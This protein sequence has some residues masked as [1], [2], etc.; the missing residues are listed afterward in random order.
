VVLDRSDGL[1]A[2]P[3]RDVAIYVCVPNLILRCKGAGAA[4]FSCRCDLP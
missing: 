3:Q 4:T 2:V 1:V